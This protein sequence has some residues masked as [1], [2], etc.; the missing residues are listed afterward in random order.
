MERDLSADVLPDGVRRNSRL[1]WR[2][3]GQRPHPSTAKLKF[4]CS[5]PS[6]LASS[7]GGKLSVPSRLPVGRTGRRPQQRLH[8]A[9]QRNATHPVRPRRD[10][11][12]HGATSNGIWSLITNGCDLPPT[13]LFTAD[14]GRPT[15]RSQL[16]R[17]TASQL[18]E[19]MWLREP[20]RITSRIERAIRRAMVGA[21]LNPSPPTR[22]SHQPSSYHHPD[23][24]SRSSLALPARTQ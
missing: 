18:P 4:P 3:L 16:G 17:L 21:G 8:Q 1:L 5:R 12:A 19:P 15:S 7:L 13:E 6:C 24:S 14:L 22:G 23:A 2:S 11:V 20:A 10:P 9:H